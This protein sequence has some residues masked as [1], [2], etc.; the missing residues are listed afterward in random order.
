MIDLIEIEQIK[1]KNEDTSEV[2]TATGWAP[3]GQDKAQRWKL[4]DS[5]WTEITGIGMFD[6]E[7]REFKCTKTDIHFVEVK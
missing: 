5:S 2:L 3:E 7:S 1:V 4:S 6:D